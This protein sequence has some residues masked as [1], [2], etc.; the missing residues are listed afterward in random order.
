M[1]CFSLKYSACE[2][3]FVC[4][5][6]CKSGVHKQSLDNSVTCV[7]AGFEDDIFGALVVEV[8]LEVCE[9]GVE[10]TVRCKSHVRNFSVAVPHYKAA[11][12]DIL[13]SGE[14][15]E[16]YAEVVAVAEVVPV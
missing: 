11:V 8:Y 1:F 5:V 15:A 13:Y 2:V 16:A 14:G 7:R 10:L 12:A 4:V 9:Y 3:F 6:R